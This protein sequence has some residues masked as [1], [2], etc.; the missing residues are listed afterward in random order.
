M[1]GTN[2]LGLLLT[3]IDLAPE[4]EGDAPSVTQ[5]RIAQRYLEIHWEHARPYP[6]GGRTVTLRQSSARKRRSDG[7][8]ADDTT[9]M[10]EIHGLRELL[11]CGD[12]GDLREKP[13]EIV[14]RR[15]DGTDLQSEWKE[16]YETAL[17]K[18]RANLLRNP[19]RLL[20]RLPG[21][22]E[23]FLY[24][25]TSDKSALTFLPGVARS[26]TRF[27][28]VLRPLIEF[29]FAQAVMRINRETLQL[30]IDDVYSH[31][32]GRDRIMPSPKMRQGLV[33]IQR[34]QCIFTDIRLPKAGGSLDHVVPWSR[35][36]LSQ[37]ENFVMTTPSVNS[38]KSDSLLTP[39]AMERWFQHI[40]TNSGELQECADEHGWL[41]DFDSV[42]R[43]AL[44][45]YRALDA[46]T[47]VWD[48]EHGIQLLGVDGKR[49]VL[50]LLSSPASST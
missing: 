47:G 8:V 45:I 15:L 14:E 19:V 36:R 26:L 43:V 37:I 28:G 27:A 44:H 31:L 25:V 49:A 9:V 48:F 12:R 10:Q 4:L 18:V 34:G 7:T 30:P 1:T 42:R 24:D 2:K 33:E 16:A 21:D 11:E 3:L 46:S 38:S 20:Q 40:D 5:T 50:E 39:A 32:F 23:P 29:R 41:T 35:A 22:P 13:L 6:Y 17:A